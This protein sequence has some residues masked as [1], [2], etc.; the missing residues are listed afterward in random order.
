[1]AS[2]WFISCTHHPLH[3]LR[4]IWISV[5]VASGIDAILPSP[6]QKMVHT[7]LKCEQPT[8]SLT[9]KVYFVERCCCGCCCSC[10]LVTQACPILFDLMYYSPPGSS[11]HGVLQLRILQGVA[12]P[13]SR[14]SSQPRD[15]TQV[16]HN[17]GRF[18]SFWA[19]RE[20]L[21]ELYLLPITLLVRDLQTHDSFGLEHHVINYLLKRIMG[22]I[23]WIV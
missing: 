14:G 17:A 13:F 18:F 10:C 20:A 4:V 8:Q 6:S 21:I 5:M 3:L 1:M 7:H 12:I 23:Y 16:S 11:A 15:Q 2:Q 9:S 19:T 22:R